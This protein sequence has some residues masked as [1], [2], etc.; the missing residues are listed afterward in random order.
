MARRCSG[1][2]GL[3][4]WRYQWD[5]DNLQWRPLVFDLTESD[6]GVPLGRRPAGVTVS[7]WWSPA[8]LGYLIRNTGVYQL[9]SKI[10][11]RTSLVGLRSFEVK[12]R[13]R[14][15]YIDG[16]IET[17]WET[18][19]FKSAS[20]DTVNITVASSEFLSQDMTVRVEVLADIPTVVGNT[21]HGLVLQDT[22]TNPMSLF[23]IHLI[24]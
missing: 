3:A 24:N 8:E 11:F 20:E 22:L 21:T 12:L 5:N 7:Q 13:L 23:R 19:Q 10:H 9:T 14:A 17:L 2:Y 15:K 6:Y 16:R 4:D 18:R 1:K